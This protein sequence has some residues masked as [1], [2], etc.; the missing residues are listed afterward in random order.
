MKHQ[1]NEEFG[2]DLGDSKV[3]YTLDWMVCPNKNIFTE[4]DSVL[5]AKYARHDA[6]RARCLPYS[7][8]LPARYISFV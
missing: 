4:K 6:Q 8:V 5:L 1:G 2:P 7:R 3:Q